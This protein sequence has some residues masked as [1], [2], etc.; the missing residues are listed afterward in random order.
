MRLP[1]WLKASI[2]TGENQSKISEILEQGNLNTICEEASCPNRGECWNHGTATFLILGNICSRNCLYCNVKH[3]IPNKVDLTEPKKIADA[4]KILNLNYAVVTSVTRDDLEDGGSGIFADCITEIKKTSPKTR[5]EVLIP[6]FGFNYISLKKVVDAKP[7]VINHN[8]EVTENIFDEIRPLGNY[9]RSLA[10]LKKIKEL[11]VKMTSKSGF[12]LG[13]GECDVDIK[14]TINDLKE[15]KI[16]ILTIGQYL[17]PSKNNAEVVKFYTPDEF[18]F[19]K[20]YALSIGFAYVESGP[21]VRSS[22]HAE[23]SYTKKNLYK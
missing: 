21:L 15:S 6:D 20:N 12:M 18:D 9:K 23:K 5:I 2:P 19:F 16:D 3:G 4:I 1:K 10:L 8:I 22:Y 14:K 7:N 13:L 17:R 11:D